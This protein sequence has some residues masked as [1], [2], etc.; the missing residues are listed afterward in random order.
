M[1]F[2]VASIHLGDPNKFIRPNMGLNIDDEA[3]STGGRFFADF[4]L[5]VYIEFA[6]K[7]ML[8][9][10]QQQEMIANLPKWVSTQPFVIDA[11]APIANPTKDQMRLMVQSLLADR[12]KLALHFE[13]H[14][15]PVMALVQVNPGKLGPRLRPHSE[16]PPCDA[17]IPP[18]DRSSPKIP[19]VWIPV[20]GT[21]QN[22]DWANNTVILGSRDTTMD[23]FADYV[24]LLQPFDRPVVDQTGLS[25]RFDIEVNFTPPWKMP[26]GQTADTQLDLTGPTLLEGLKNDL[27]LKLI[28]THAPV[29]TLVIDHVEQPSPN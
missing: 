23:V 10:E 21:T 17:K 9:R 19:E 29:R 13:T 11:K 4:P 15:M 25:G 18:V 16:G 1:E 22:I 26:K 24:G 27:G 28:S 14:D 3:I 7:V 8:T 5:P 20:C 2:E 6:Y 12:F